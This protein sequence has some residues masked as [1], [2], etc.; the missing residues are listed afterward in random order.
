MDFSLFWRLLLLLVFFT[1]IVGR[2][3]GLRRTLPK[4]DQT[5]Q[6]FANFPEALCRFCL[7]LEVQYGTAAFHGLR[8]RRHFKI[9]GNCYGTRN[10]VI[11]TCVLALSKKYKLPETN[12]RP[13]NYFSK[14]KHLGIHFT[15]NH[16][17][18]IFELCSYL[19]FFLNFSL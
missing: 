3:D 5:F 6:L 17:L 1:K 10:W 7:K 19:T 4:S 15:I 18:L 2:I 9:K 16:S 14:K 11:K 13:Q 12:L 8:A